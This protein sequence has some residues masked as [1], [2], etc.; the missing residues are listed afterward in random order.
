MHQG[1]ETLPRTGGLGLHLMRT[2]L[3]SPL[4]LLQAHSCPAGPR[5]SQAATE[6]GREVVPPGG[7]GTGVWG[8]A[9]RDPPAPGD[10]ARGRNKASAQTTGKQWGLECRHLPLGPEQPGRLPGGMVQGTHP[11]VL[12]T[13][14]GLPAKHLPARAPCPGQEALTTGWPGGGRPQ[15]LCGPVRRKSDFGVSPQLRGNLGSRQHAPSGCRA[16]FPLILPDDPQSRALC[17][18]A[19]PRK[20]LTPP[21]PLLPS[22]SCKPPEQSW[23]VTSGKGPPGCAS[24]AWI[25]HQSTR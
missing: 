17:P 10:M 15:W 2:P 18:P 9:W 1:G 21:S 7:T 8:C 11:S 3:P 13:P 25:C 14:E 16:R 5:G 6:T 12:L 19:P 24:H 22:P 4:T 23:E 20:P